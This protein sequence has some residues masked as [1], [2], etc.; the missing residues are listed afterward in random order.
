VNITVHQNDSISGCT[1]D[2]VHG[3][4]LVLEIRWDP[5]PTGPSADDY[6]V[7]V[8]DGAGTEIIAPFYGVVQVHYDVPRKRGPT[9]MKKV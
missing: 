6:G 1:F 7:A 5:P 9:P 8:A 4:G 3:Y 2:P